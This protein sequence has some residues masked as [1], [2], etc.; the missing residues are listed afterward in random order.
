MEQNINLELENI[1]TW[2]RVNKLSLNIGK[3][4]HTIFNKQKRRF[5]HLELKIENQDIEHTCKTKFLGVI[6]DQ[7]LTWKPHMALM[8]GKIA[9]GIGMIIKV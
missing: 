1:S 5:V 7:K 4:H 9:R 8:S 6:I 2:L 3:T